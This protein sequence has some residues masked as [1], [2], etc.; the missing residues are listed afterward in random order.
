MQIYADDAND[1]GLVQPEI[2]E[3]NKD[4]WAWSG[5]RVIWA[6]KC[7]L[8]SVQAEGWPLFCLQQVHQLPELTKPEDNPTFIPHT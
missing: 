8:S 7:A 5:P 4:L 1:Q 3:E 2:H 6:S